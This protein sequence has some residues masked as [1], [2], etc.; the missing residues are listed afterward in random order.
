METKKTKT[1]SVNGVMHEINVES[2]FAALYRDGKAKLSEHIKRTIFA[3]LMLLCFSA[4]VDAQSKYTIKGN[5]IV[6]VEPKQ[7][8]ST[9]K[10]ITTKMT[11]TTPDGKKHQ[12]MLSAKGRAYIE[13]TSKNGNVYK[14]YFGEDV[15][16]ELCKQYGITYVEKTK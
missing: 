4:S 12:V 13:R 15:S 16:R 1:E 9:S 8:E 10:S 2:L 5:E 6:R 3:V 11:H 7:S 14:Q